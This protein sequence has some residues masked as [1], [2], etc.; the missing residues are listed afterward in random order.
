M[1]TIR[2]VVQL[3]YMAHTHF[4]QRDNE[5]GAGEKSAETQCHSGKRAQ[6]GLKR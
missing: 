1:V 5:K 3:E 6:D 4:A 2:E